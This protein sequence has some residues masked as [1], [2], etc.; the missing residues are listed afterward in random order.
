[1]TSKPAKVYLET[2]QTLNEKS[3]VLEIEVKNKTNKSIEIAITI[4]ALSQALKSARFALDATEG[5]VQAYGMTDRELPKDVT[6]AMQI[7]SKFYAEKRE[8]WSDAL[9]KAYV[10][11]AQV[12]S[13]L[14]FLMRQWDS[15]RYKIN[16]MSKVKEDARE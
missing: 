15:I 2:L 5:I 3:S 7:V 1:M 12:K 14:H 9:D 16:K 13:E 8:L 10:Q 11:H 6:L 4:D